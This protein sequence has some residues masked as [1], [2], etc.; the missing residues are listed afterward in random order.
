MVNSDNIGWGNNN[1]NPATRTVGTVD[2]S[3]AYPKQI[4]YK[5]SEGDWN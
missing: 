2:R 4:C 5:D 1:A 3:A